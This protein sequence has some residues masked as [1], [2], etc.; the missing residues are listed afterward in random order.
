[1][2][3]SENKL[4]TVLAWIH[5]F[6]ILEGSYFLAAGIFH[7]EKS[8]AQMYIMKGFLLF[9]PVICSFFCMRIIGNLWIYLAVSVLAVLGMYTVSGCVLTGVLTGFV[10]LVRCHV[11]IRR[12]KIKRMLQ[13]MPGEA[14]AQELPEVWEIPTFFDRPSPHYWSVFVIYYVVAIIGGMKEYLRGIWWLLAADIAICLVCCYI[15]E[16]QDF[17]ERNRRIANLPVRAM[18]KVGKQIFVV[19]MAGMILFMLPAVIYDKEPLAE[20]N[21]EYHGAP[22]KLPEPEQKQQGASMQESLE[23]LGVEGEVREFPQWIQTVLKVIPAV[24]FVGFLLVILRTVGKALKNAA[25]A[26]SQE[27]E[28]VLGTEDEEVS[29]TK[30]LKTD[31]EKGEGWFSPN[32]RIRRKYK[33]KVLRHSKVRPLGTETPAQI[34]TKANLSG[35]ERDVLHRLYEKARYSSDGCTKEEAGKL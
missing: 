15:E 32:M 22:V 7:M 16:M 17:I 18:K 21:L 28:A 6:F 33:K 9:I 5:T 3:N 2:R 13:E 26:F 34:E 14:G 35:E 11:R 20:I 10:F 12:G 31:R 30:K 8:A 1:M 24:L 25:D 29:L 27:E 4:Q 19:L 23:K